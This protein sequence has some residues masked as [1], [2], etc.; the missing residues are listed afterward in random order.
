MHLCSLLLSPRF[1]PLIDCCCVPVRPRRCRL[2]RAHRPRPRPRQPLPL[3]FVPSYQTQREALLA[4]EAARAAQASLEENR[5]RAAEAQEQAEKARQAEEAALSA[6]RKHRAL[7]VE[8]RGASDESERRCGELRDWQGR[9]RQREEDIELEI[10]RA[11]CAP[12]PPSLFTLLC[13]LAPV[14]PSINTPHPTL[15]G[16]SRW[17]GGESQGERRFTRGASR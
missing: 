13:R 4:E 9:A 3:R 16:V 6:L 2:L 5:R 15:T 10:E 14:R 17:A 12:S 7:E 1:Q 11:T 8:L